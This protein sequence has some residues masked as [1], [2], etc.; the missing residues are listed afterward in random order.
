MLFSEGLDHLAAGC[1]LLGL[2]RARPVDEKP[3]SAH[4]ATD[5]T[6]GIGNLAE[7]L[8]ISHCLSGVFLL[9]LLYRTGWNQ[10]TKYLHQFILSD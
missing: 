6:D 10:D 1:V 9:E 3:L 4:L 5:I 8:H 2:R 7:N